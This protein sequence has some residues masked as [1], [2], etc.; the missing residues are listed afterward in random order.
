MQRDYR[1]EF[2]EGFSITE[3]MLSPHSIA[4]QL[5]DQISLAKVFVVI[6]KDSNNLKFAWDLT[7]QIRNLQVLLSTAARG[8]ISLTEEESKPAIREM[9][10][11]LYQAQ[12]LQYDIATLIMKLK[13]KVLSLEE[14]T[15]AVKDKS[16]KYG[17]IAAEEVPKSLYCLGVRLATK[18]FKSPKLRTR[19][20]LVENKLK[21]NKLYH[22][23]VFSDN[24]LAT[25]VVV[26]STA[27]TSNNPNLVVFHR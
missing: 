19:E 12:Q 4:R 6:A 1:N 17:Q 20:V 2:T 24:I 9:A 11:M 8:Q 10:L 23:C 22:F 27:L 14:Q 3:E 7:A 26:N 5:N 16:L 13:S 15:N 18:W 21:D 25:S